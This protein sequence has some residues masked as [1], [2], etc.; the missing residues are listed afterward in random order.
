MIGGLC[1]HECAT[2]VAPTYARTEN[3]RVPALHS[4]AH[5]AHAP[6]ADR[7]NLAS[8]SGVTQLITKS[9]RFRFLEAGHG[10]VGIM[11][12]AKAVHAVG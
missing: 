8:E 5:A 2:T 7:M 1:C 11:C 12:E 3:P 10:G 4:R 9:T 6:A